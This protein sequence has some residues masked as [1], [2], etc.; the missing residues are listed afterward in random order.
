MG[1]PIQ[2]ILSALDSSLSVVQGAVKVT[3]PA[4]FRE[5]VHVLAE[6]SALE[7]GQK[8]GLARFLTRAAALD[9]DIH[10]ASIHEF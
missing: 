1:T 9:L 2:D 3:N 6:L 8:Q 4:R 7:T 5:K 10:P